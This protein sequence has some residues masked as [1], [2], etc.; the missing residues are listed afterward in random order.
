M[1]VTM[2]PAR[3]LPKIIVHRKVAAYCRVSTQQ[4]IQHHSLEAQREYYEKRITG[5]SG[6]E[7]VGIY[8]D[9][10]SGRNNLKMHDFQRMM[11]DCHAGKIDLIITKSISRLGRNTLQ[12]LNACE[13]LKSLNVDVLF[14]VEKLYLHNPKAVRL[15][16]IYASV[17]QNESEVKSAYTRWGI[18]T[19]YANGTSAT[20]NLPCYGYR[21][22]VNGELVIEPAEAVV[23]RMIYDLRNQGLSL[24]EI[25]HEL[26]E[27]TIPSP[28]GKATWGVETV[29]RI[30]QNEKYKGH[31]LLQK[32]YVS[33][34]ITGK[35]A[36]NNGELPKYLLEGH[37][38]AIIKPDEF[39]TF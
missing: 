36:T 15:L 11:E 22:D 7:F 25:A 4:E 30:L 13:E 38:E 21:R 18:R 12:F 9:Q 19:R 6:W 17:Y 1:K 24:R 2:R 23:V 35:R 34:F 32:T 26:K 5:N 39:P 8:T 29:R 37:H 33:N 31:V 10:A 14:E 16:T 20:A 27:R 3:A 28:S